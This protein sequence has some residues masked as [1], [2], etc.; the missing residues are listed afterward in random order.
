MTQ[1]VKRP[2]NSTRRQQQAEETR[3]RILD[4]AA[5]VFVERGYE[6]ASVAAIA[7]AAGVADETVYGHFKNKRT[8]LGEVV[9]R[10]VRGDDSRPVPAQRE[11]RALI[12]ETD[13]RRQLDLFAADVTLRLDR[14]ARLVALVA[15]AAPG[16]PELGEL[17]RRLHADRLKNLRVLVDALRVNGQLRSA[18][19][20][21]TETVWAL[22]SPELY[23]LLT[24]VRG[25]S[26]KRYSKWLAD[27]LTDI[28]LGSAATAAR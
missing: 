3:A 12:A 11:A 14:A 18:P 16:E 28:L 27:S 22:A 8:V 6:R 25:W 26:R 20:A 21:A 19:A 10:A 13:Q 1:S 4:A 7:A 9:K 2:Y 24:R 5:E 17:L 15:E 23:E